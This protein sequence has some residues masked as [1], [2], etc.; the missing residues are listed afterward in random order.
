MRRLAS[1]DAETKVH[2]MFEK[3]A[4][5]AEEAKSSKPG[6]RRSQIK[7]DQSREHILSTSGSTKAD[8]GENCV[9]KDISMNLKES[10]IGIPHIPQECNI[11]V[12]C[13]NCGSETPAIYVHPPSSGENGIS[14]VS[15]VTLA[16]NHFNLMPTQCVKT[17]SQISELF[18]D[19]DAL[20][21]TLSQL[22]GQRRA[23]VDSAECDHFKTLFKNRLS[24]RLSRHS[25][26]EGEME[27]ISSTLANQLS[28]LINT[29][30]KYFCFILIPCLSLSSHPVSHPLLL[31]HFPCQR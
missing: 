13:L 27:R 6:R 20:M 14:T 11:A 28:S 31:Q 1:L 7:S 25:V 22:A 26:S 2:L 18:N 4:I 30:C 21:R 5:Q 12:T 29:R 17:S 24:Y 19:P 9:P 15:P 3:E 23:S 16:K 8:V 10:P